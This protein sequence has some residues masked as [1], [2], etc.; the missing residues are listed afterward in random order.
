MLLA[1]VLL[2]LGGTAGA[3]GAVNP[4]AN[5]PFNPPFA[6]YGTPTAPACENAVVAALDAARA[7]LGLG[8]YLL[9]A[10][11]DTLPATEQIFILAN[12]DRQAYALPVIGGLSATL[13]T[14]ASA[15]VAADS[16][17]DPV[18][19]L[20]AGLALEGWDSNWG[21]GFV[22]A[23]DAYYEWMYDDGVGSPNLDCTAA[24]DPGCWGHRDDVLS[25]SSAGSLLMGAAQGTDGSATAGYAM[26]IVASQEASTSWTTL[27]YTWADA[28]ADLAG[29]SS[30]A[31]GSSSPSP[32]PSGSTTGSSAT[33]AGDQGAGAQPPAPGT[34]PTSSAS[35]PTPA[36]ATPAQPAAP[37][38]VI[39]R[40]RRSGGHAIRFVLR[41][42]VA[43][44]RFQCALVR[45]G[46]TQRPRFRRCGPI[47]VYRHLTAG[48]YTF[49]AR[50]LAKGSG[51]RR[52]ARRSFVVA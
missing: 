9:P 33:A 2:A 41:A 12:L 24:G 3:W 32:A 28:L 16:D 21:G 52:P 22:N 31:G 5:I 18:P 19:Y 10:D 46:T 29:A 45:A 20:P 8:P 11:F 34:S 50:A 37:L 47:R 51:A 4:A 17:P 23:P 35:V 39:A 6:C 7:D 42:S 25:F 14:A 36:A 13:N 49:F 26:T 15:G 48:R 43:S 44:A 38:A 1:V 40:V 27:T 30:S